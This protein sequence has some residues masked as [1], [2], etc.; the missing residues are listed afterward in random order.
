MV[1]YSIEKLHEILKKGEFKLK[2]ELTENKLVASPNQP[3]EFR[4]DVEKELE[5]CLLEDFALA[6]S[7]PA[8]KNRLGIA[9]EENEKNLELAEEVVQRFEL[10]FKPDTPRL[11]MAP[12]LKLSPEGTL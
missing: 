5:S 12:K 11:I 7:P 10:Q 9:M 1:E 8:P 4:D 6:L 2:Y 3:L